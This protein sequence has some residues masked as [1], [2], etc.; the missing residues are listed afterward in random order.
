MKKHN[1]PDT[2]ADERH[3]GEHRKPLTERAQHFITEYLL[4]EMLQ[5]DT[6]VMFILLLGEDKVKISQ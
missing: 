6:I 3:S 5:T 1:Q 4:Q 2:E